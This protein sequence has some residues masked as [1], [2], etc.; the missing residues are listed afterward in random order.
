MYYFDVET[1]PF[2][3]STIS[4]ENIS[5]WLKVNIK[6]HRVYLTISPNNGKKRSTILKL[7][8]NEFPFKQRFIKIIQ[9]GTKI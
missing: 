6:E 5:R 8:N 3:D 7:T 4:Y 9:K 2:D 1:Y